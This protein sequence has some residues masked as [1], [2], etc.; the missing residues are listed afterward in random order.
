MNYTKIS[1][2]VVAILPILF[3]LG[4]ASLNVA[5]VLIFCSFFWLIISKKIPTNSLYNE[6][7]KIIFFI[8]FFYT[9]I[10]SIFS[11]EN[12]NALRSSISQ[13]RFFV[14]LL[15]L[16]YF[17]DTKFL[18][19]LIVPCWSIIILLVCLD[20]NLQFFTG[21]DIFGYKAEGFGG[22]NRVLFSENIG[23]LGGPFGDELIVGSFISKT[24][25]P[26][27]F[28]YMLKLKKLNY[29]YQILTIFF[30][31]LI[32][33][34][35]LISGER[36]SFLITFLVFIFGFFYCF[37]FR[38]IALSFSIIIFSLTVA[39]AS[40]N[41]LKSRYVEVIKII[42]D[43]P[44]SSYGRIYSSS[45]AIWKEN[46]LFGVGNKNYHVNCKKLIDPNPQSKYSYCSP[47]H[48]HNNILQFLVEL[49]LIGTIIFYIFIFYLFVFFKNNLKYLRTIDEDN[50]SFFTG[51]SIVT[52]YYIFPSIIPAGSFFTTWNATFFW[53]HLGIMLSIIKN[54]EK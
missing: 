2:S 37:K 17:F 8:F 50:K 18:K 3:I 32:F 25:A 28:Y 45:Y 54:N 31:I 13:I 22:D 26:L 29:N 20:T 53:L 51:S 10:I 43:L 42:N 7:W 41:F 44:S 34:T 24:S 21:I 14:L 23:R 16:Y 19:L 5:L 35:V 1:S 40:T 30:L 46:I 15:F 27:I 4:S 12:D 36:T 47:N 49:G 6:N 9:I 33:E 52:I 11:I 38:T 39:F 48:S